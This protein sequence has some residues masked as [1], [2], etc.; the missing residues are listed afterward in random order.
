MKEITSDEYYRKL[1]SL[2]RDE[3]Q[4][5]ID[6]V[7][8]APWRQGYHVQPV[9]GYMASPAAFFYDKGV[10]H[11][12]YNWY[13]ISSY[14]GINY[15]YHVTSTDLVTFSNQGVKLRP[16]DLYDSHGISAGSCAMINGDPHLFYTGKF[17]DKEGEIVPVQLV[18]ELDGA[19]KLQKHPIPLIEEVPPHISVMRQPYVFNKDGDYYML[20]GAG[21]NDG[22]GRVV[23]YSAVEPD[24]FT[25]RGELSTHL[26]TFGFMWE[27]PS[28]FELDGYDVLMF[29]PQGIDKVGHNFWNVYQAGFVIGNFNSDELEMTHGAFFELD[30]GFDFYAPMTA[31]DKKGNRVMTGLLG[32]HD[33]GYPTD[34]YDWTNCLTVPRVLTIE[35]YKLKQRPHPNLTALRQEEISALGYFKHHPKRMRDFYG[36][37]YELIIDFHEYDATEIYIKLRVSKREETIITYNTSSQEVTLDTSFSGVM[38]E[39]VDGTERTIKLHEGLKDLQI[40]MDT[41]SIEIFINDGARVMSARIFPSDRSTGVELSTETGECFVNMTQYLLPDIPSE[42][43]I[44][45]RDKMT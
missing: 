16:D 41:S 1:D 33:T 30:Y 20:L 6:K 42:K 34:E 17:K 27:H 39:G 2:N 9:S 19:D 43:I 13:P 4:E 11:I 28:I 23:V 5:L 29:C 40:F 12:F 25:Y 21:N 18:A 36:E 3:Q 22:F 10:Y 14:N 44:F 38:P 7:A 26:D 15:W 32:M 8:D 37:R 45:N 24:V 35:D 31:L